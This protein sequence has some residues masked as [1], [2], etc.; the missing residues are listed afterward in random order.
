MQLSFIVTLKNRCNIKVDYNNTTINLK[1]FENNIKSLCSTITPAD[2]WE[3]VIVDFKSDD[4]TLH[5]WI[6]TLGIPENLEIKIIELDETFN[7]GKGLNRGIA[8]AK[9]STIFCYDADMSIFTRA[10]FTD[11][12]TYVIEQGKV[13]FPICWSYH[14]P[15]HSDGWKRVYGVGMVILNKEQHIPYIEKNSWGLEDV[16]NFIYFYKKGLSIRTYYEDR[17]IHQW[18]PNDIDF[19]NKYYDINPKEMTTYVSNEDMKIY[20]AVHSHH[21]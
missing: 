16:N 13:L 19:K 3:L 7:R 17:Y 11:I 8:A 21:V 4:V 9:Y 20:Y 10:L 14:T 5:E 12:Q 18:H 6:R 1:L 2:R 15:A